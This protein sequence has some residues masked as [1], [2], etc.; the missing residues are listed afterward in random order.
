MSFSTF[1]RAFGISASLAP[2]SDS[3]SKS[4]E[5]RGRRRKVHIY[6][7]CRTKQGKKNIK[8]L[9]VAESKKI[10][11]RQRRYP[12]KN[13]EH[14]E[15][16]MKKKKIRKESSVKKKYQKHKKDFWGRITRPPSPMEGNSL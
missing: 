3:N 7:Q 9:E 8:P 15:C 4:T 13:P 12:K 10:K 6:L 1:N 14:A 2:K 11:L 16:S 5:R